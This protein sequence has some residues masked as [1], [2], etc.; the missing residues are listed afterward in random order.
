MAVFGSTGAVGRLALEVVAHL[1]D[2]LKL[3]AIA[4]HQAVTEIC[5]QAERYRPR[6]VLLTDEAAAGRVRSRLGP[7]WR[8][9]GGVQALA[10]FAGSDEIDLLVMAM[11]GTAGL[12]PV[13]AAL[14]QGKRVALASKELLVVYGE[15]LL[16]LCRRYRGTLLP[17]DSELAGV[18]QCL[19]G[20]DIAEVRRV[21]LTASGGPFRRTGPPADAPVRRVLRHPVWQMGKKITVDSATLMNKGLEV[22]ETVRYFG[23]AP[24]Q[25]TAV[26]H[27]ESVVHALVELRDGSVL[28]QLS[29][30]DM[31]LPIQYCLTWP[32]RQ[33]S[34]VR[35]LDWERMWTL[36]FE[37]V[38]PERFPCFGL[39]YR[40]LGA[41]SG[42]TCVLSAA[43][44]VAVAAF[45]GGRIALGRIPQIIEQTLDRFSSERQRQGYS[46]SRLQKLERQA[47]DYARQLIAQGGKKG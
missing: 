18:H 20:R 40:A 32:E 6:V 28:A 24:E 31:R 37:P 7:G 33:A 36:H 4:A 9:R 47:G 45:L 39:A 43:N 16:R 27:P 3:V 22:I 38:D 19:A 17:L 1:S 23:L 13:V 15:P 11:S 5:R 14:R 35:F 8:V 29:V 34:L 30:P 44:D 10:Q 2:R 12:E 41:G 42:G 25:V 46:I 26:I 21:I